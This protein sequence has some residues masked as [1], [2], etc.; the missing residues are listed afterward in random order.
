[1]ASRPT[2]HCYRVVPGKLP[3]GEYPGNID[4]GSSRA[5]LDRLTEVGISAHGDVGLY[6]RLTVLRRFRRGGSARRDEG[7]PVVHLVFPR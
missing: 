7:C 4:D 5:K 2:E 1:M 3:A 6:R